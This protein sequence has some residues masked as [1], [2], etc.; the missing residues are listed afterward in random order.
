MNRNYRV[1]FK[2]LS[3]DECDIL[4]A[5][6][7]SLPSGGGELSFAPSEVDGTDRLFLIEGDRSV[8]TFVF[9][10]D[11]ATTGKWVYE[12]ECNVCDLSF[13]AGHYAERC[14]ACEDASIQQFET[15]NTTI[16]KAN[17]AS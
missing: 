2:A 13:H 7:P 5:A 17:L 3:S 16:N 4:A 8:Q 14:D 11:Y 10:D 9:A 12:N 15:Y 1:A 6:L